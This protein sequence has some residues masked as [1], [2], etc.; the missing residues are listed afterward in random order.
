GP[1]EPTPIESTAAA[2]AD[3]SPEP[4]MARAPASAA[5]A[6]PPAAPEQ[7]ALTQQVMRGLRVTAT[8]LGREV[9]LRLDP[10]EL[11]RVHMTLQEDA[12]G[13]RGVLRVERAE[14]AEQLQRETNDLLQ[15][16]AGD[17]MRVRRIEIIVEPAPTDATTT[18]QNSTQQHTGGQDP[19][20]TDGQGERQP[21]RQNGDGDASYG[22]EGQSANDDRPAQASDEDESINLYR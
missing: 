11:G 5:G 3:F 18:S 8:Q 10:P 4:I 17:G 21:G 7:P 9:S 22:D 6:S 1:V 20:D 16:L 15:R 2:A 19:Q 13:L 14:T 12:D